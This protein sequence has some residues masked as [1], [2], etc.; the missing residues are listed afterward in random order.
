M[1]KGELRS[2]CPGRSGSSRTR[3]GREAAE[4]QK[5][6]RTAKFAVP[7]SPRSCGAALL[8][9]NKGSRSSPSPSPCPAGAVTEVKTDIYVTSFGPVSDVEMVRAPLGAPALFSRDSL[10]WHLS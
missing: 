9:S 8:P 1:G 2:G 6:R 7:R 3:S 10:R 5:R 4:P